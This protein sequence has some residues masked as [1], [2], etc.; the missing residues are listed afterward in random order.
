MKKDAHNAEL[1]PSPANK[2]SAD[3]G[4]TKPPNPTRMGTPLPDHPAGQNMS[5]Q[6]TPG[7]LPLSPQQHPLQKEQTP[8]PGT[9][10]EGSVRDK[11]LQENASLGAYGGDSMDSDED[12]FKSADKERDTLDLSVIQHEYQFKGFRSGIY[13]TQADGKSNQSY[14]TNMHANVVNTNSTFHVDSILINDYN[15]PEESLM[16]LTEMQ[17]SEYALDLRYDVYEIEIQ[18]FTN[19][20]GTIDMEFTEIGK[21][22]EIISTNIDSVRIDI[23]LAEIDSLIE[24]C[25]ALNTEVDQLIIDTKQERY[26]KKRFQK[27]K[28]EI[29]DRIELFENF[30]SQNRPPPKHDLHI[31]PHHK[32]QLSVQ[33]QFEQIYKAAN[34]AYIPKEQVAVVTTQND[35]KYADKCTQTVD[36]D[37]QCMTKQMLP[38]QQLHVNTIPLQNKIQFPEQTKETPVDAHYSENNLYT[39]VA[40]QSR[41]NQLIITYTNDDRLKECTN[42]AFDRAVSTSTKT[43][44]NQL[45]YKTSEPSKNALDS[46]VEVNVPQSDRVATPPNLSQELLLESGQNKN[47]LLLHTFGRSASKAVDCMNT[48]IGSIGTECN[49]IHDTMVENSRKTKSNVDNVFIEQIMHRKAILATINTNNTSN[50]ENMQTKQRRIDRNELK[51]SWRVNDLTLGD[52]ELRLQIKDCGWFGLNT[53]IPNMLNNVQKTSEMAFRKYL[54]KTTDATKRQPFQTL[55]WDDDPEENK[56]IERTVNAKFNRLPMIQEIEEPPL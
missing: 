1:P 44:E 55:S 31:T 37:N 26:Y 13:R 2:Q 10:T 8:P 29:S 18:S 23:K 32:P 7:H 56:L 19:A 3:A 35:L 11:E 36:S 30:L 54:T 40:R 38:C 48:N 4:Y 5:A 24:E 14:I 45:H 21:D 51:E 20:L 15:I 34:D 50:T 52:T 16:K 25:K 22:I 42:A 33:E 46:S 41:L 47:I 27:V 6:T 17:K 49:D 9:G 53:P 12:S 28:G 39:P 43:T